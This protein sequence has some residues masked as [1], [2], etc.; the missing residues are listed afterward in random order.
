VVEDYLRQVATS[1]LERFQHIGLAVSGGGDSVAMLWLV[2]PWAKARGV[3][4]SVATVDHG[5]RPEAAEEA[6]FV[7]ELCREVGVP[8]DTLR[9]TGWNGRGNLQA[10]AREARRRLLTEWAKERGVDAVLLAHTQDDQA[11]TFLL[12]LA[13]GSGVDGLSGITQEMVEK[14]LCWHRPL[15]SESRAALRAYLGRMGRHWSTIPQTRSFAMIGSRPDGSCR[16][17]SR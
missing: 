9:W 7:E 8:H 1:G 3:P 6:R 4:V 10:R 11:E 17:L 13:R 14:G 15:L 5:L 12:R 2:A 16:S